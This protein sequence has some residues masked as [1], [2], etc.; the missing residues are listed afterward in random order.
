MTALSRIKVIATAMATLG[1]V[2]IACADDFSATFD[3]PTIDRWMYPFNASPGTRIIGSTFGST[4]GD[5]DFDN[6]DGELVI[7][8]S[9]SSEIP[10]GLGAGAYT[11]VSARLTI[12]IENDLAVVYDNTLDSFANF[13]LP[14]DPNY[15]EDSDPGQPFELFGAG[16]RD[17]FTA[18]TFPENGPYSAIGPFGKGIRTVFPLGFDGGTAVDVANS[19]DEQ[20]DPQPFAVGH[21][22]GLTP[23]DLIPTGEDVVF[24]LNVADSDVHDYLATAINDGVLTLC[25]T[26]FTRVE[27]M[28]GSFPSFYLKEHPNVT[29]GFNNAA[30]LEL[31]V[32]TGAVDCPADIDQSGGV[33]F[34]DLLAVLSA[35]GPC[36]GCDADLDDSGAVNFSDLVAVLAAWGPC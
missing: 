28:G 14:E 21:M 32:T 23:G 2:T 12:Q 18:Q 5:P 25:V 7:G 34:A 16:F 26:S 9:T 22:P 11:I 10:A 4:G 1:T 29:F 35:W 30:R 13:L 3:E 36:P 20:W 24:D 33:D 6:R 19:V 15:I 8:F 27:V 17:G 31:E